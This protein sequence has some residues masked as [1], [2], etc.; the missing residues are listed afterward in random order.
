M[1]FFLLFVMLAI[2]VTLFRFEKMSDSAFRSATIGVVLIELA[3]G[4]V[5]AIL[6][7]GWP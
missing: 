1:I 6:E 4:A 3:L 7:R 2:P 5:L